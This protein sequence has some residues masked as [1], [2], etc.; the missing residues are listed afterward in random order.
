MYYKNL[1]LILFITI[2]IYQ[3]LNINFEQ[4]LIR[5]IKY[6]HKYI[7]QIEVDFKKIKEYINFICN[8]KL[9]I[10]YHFNKFNIPKISFITAVYNKQQYLSQF[11]TSVQNQI[12]KEFELIIIDDF[13]TDNS[14]KIIK[15]YQDKDNRIKLIKNKKNRGTFVSRITGALHSKGEYII[16]VDPDDIILQ[17]GLYKSYNYIKK[18]NLSIVQFNAIIQANKTIKIKYKYHVYSNI[19]K[20][21][22]LSYMFY[23]NETT[24]KGDVLNTALWDKLIKR[25]IAIK[26]INFIGKDYIKKRIIIEN[27][28]ILLFSLFQN[29]DSYCY[30]NENGY[31]YIRTNNDSI[32]N[33]WENPQIC[34]LILHGIFTNI[35]FLFEKAGNT[36]LDKLYCIF[37]LKQSFKRYEICFS[38]AQKEYKFIKKILNSL[39]ISPYV[40]N[41]DKFEILILAKLHHIY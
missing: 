12:L 37:R 7:I 40:S 23:Y 19:V 16:W 10:I 2:L 15:N 21:P 36:R 34:G 14:L 28:V 25:E 32:W 6:S 1:V 4:K 24:K 41:N 5:F 33:N 9:S 8:K 29:A 38:N 18:Y 35:K 13:S 11:L 30:I 3:S 31:Y 26:T 27:D 17:N 20:Q 22:F 39:L